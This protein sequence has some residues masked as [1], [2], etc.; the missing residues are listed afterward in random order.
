M[1]TVPPAP[2]PALSGTRPTGDV[3]RH[4]VGTVA[5]EATVWAVETWR[6]GGQWDVQSV[7]GQR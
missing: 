3:T 4:V 5:L 2:L 6:T 7:R 1:T